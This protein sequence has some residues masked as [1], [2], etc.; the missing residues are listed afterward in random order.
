MVVM[1]NCKTCEY[2]KVC[3]IPDFVRNDLKSCKTYKE[4]KA[5]TNADKIRSMS[6]SE[7]AEYLHGVSEATKPCVRCSEECDFCEHSSEE[8]K[9]RVL[10]WLQEECTEDF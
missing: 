1:Q 5:K 3:E 4:K 2:E 9:N 6:N 8:C 7:L 10:K